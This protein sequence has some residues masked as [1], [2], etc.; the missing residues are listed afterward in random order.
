MREPAVAGQFYPASESELDSLF[1]DLFLHPLGAGR[2]PRYN[3]EGERNIEGGIVPHAGYIYSGPVAS[4]FYADLAE[5]GYP[6]TFVIIGPN[7]YGAGSGIATTMEDFRTP[8][9]VAKIDRELAGLLTREIVDV[10][11]LAH[12][13]EH[14][15]EVQIPFLQFFKREIQI[16]P[17][18]MMIQEQVIAEELGKVIKSA[19]EES[20][21]D[22]VIIA[23]T[24]FSHYV[25]KRK[26][27]KNDALAIERIL[28]RDIPGL[29]HVIYKKNITMCG[30]G[31]VAAMLTATRG[32]VELLKYATSGDVHPMEEVVGYASFKVNRR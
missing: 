5:D 3:N 20:G 6:D 28:N 2:I 11:E 19:I 4:H 23:S 22:V 21:K 18:T 1:S 32:R 12:R 14:S 10:D 24:D 31:P 7:H 27:Y 13:Y 17:I 25:P 15:I 29:Y 26:A 30:Y 16:V 8:Y 9:G